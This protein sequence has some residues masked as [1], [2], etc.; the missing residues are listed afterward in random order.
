[1]RLKISDVMGGKPGGVARRNDV[2][3]FRSTSD[4]TEAAIRAHRKTEA[5][6]LECVDGGSG[7]RKRRE[8][9]RKQAPLLYRCRAAVLRAEF[10]AENARMPLTK[11][12]RTLKVH[13]RMK[14]V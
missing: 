10:R 13:T 8:A 14:W 4:S 5:L 6:R 1:M 12:S 11:W 9:E 2:A 3:E 7:F